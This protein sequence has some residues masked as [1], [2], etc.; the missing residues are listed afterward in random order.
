MPP[1]PLARAGER[2]FGAAGSQCGFQ[3]GLGNAG[4]CVGTRCPINGGSWEHDECCWRMWPSAAKGCVYGPIDNVTQLPGNACSAS[5]DKAA[6]RTF[7]GWSWFR[8][9]DTQIRNATGQ[10]RFGEYCALAG[11]VVHMGDVQYCCSRSAR[12]VLDADLDLLGSRIAL[13]STAR[14]CN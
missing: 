7:G 5:W 10:V 6:T 1:D 8:T 2:C 11:S 12:G 14:I 4:F 9:V 13:R 3:Q